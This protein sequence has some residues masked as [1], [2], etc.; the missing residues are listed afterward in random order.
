[1]LI[2][3]STGTLKETSLWSNL[4]LELALLTKYCVLASHV[5]VLFTSI[6]NSLVWVTISITSPSIA[7]ENH[8]IAFILVELHFVGVG[9]IT[10]QINVLLGFHIL[11]WYDIAICWNI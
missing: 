3:S 1:M 4:S 6:P 7:I 5:S 10:N 8:S 11:A 2:R 9:P